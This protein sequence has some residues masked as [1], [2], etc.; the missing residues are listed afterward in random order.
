MGASRSHLRETQVLVTMSSAMTAAEKMLEMGDLLLV[1]RFLLIK[2][3]LNRHYL[4]KEPCQNQLLLHFSFTPEI[5][6]DYFSVVF[7]N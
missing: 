7:C 6:L 2:R 1:G 3:G 5:D 4:I